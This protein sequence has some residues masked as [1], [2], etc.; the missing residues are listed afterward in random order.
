M[1]FSPEALRALAL[2]STASVA[3]SAMDPIRW[4]MRGL[5]MGVTVPHAGTVTSAPAVQ[6]P[7]ALLPRDGR[8]G[9]GPSKVRPEAMAALAAAGRSWMGTSTGHRGDVVREVRSGLRELFALPDGWEVVLG[10]GGST[11]FW[12]VATFGLIESR[13]QHLVFG[14]FSGKFADAAARAPH[15]DAPEI[16]RS[17]PGTHP[18]PVAAASV[19]VCALTH[20]ETST[21]VM[22]DLRRPEGEALVVVDA[23]SGAGGLPWSPAEVDAYYFAPQK[24]F[25]SDGGLWL[26]AAFPTLGADR[27]D[28]HLGPLGAGLGI[29]VALENSR[30]ADLQHPAL[31]TLFLLTD[32]LRWMLRNG[33]L[34][35]C[36]ARSRRSARC[37]TAGPRAVRGEPFVPL[38]PNGRP[39]GTIDLTGSTPRSCPPPSRQRH[40]RHRLLSQAGAQPA[41]HRHVPRHPEDEALT[42]CIDHVVERLA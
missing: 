34:G 26:A 21:G 17:E 5:E 42:H 28:R 41:P 39:S 37:C 31:A 27:T 32:Q 7:A 29:C 22:M 24:C 15:L 19:D 33:G 12:D 36:V 18:A 16:I 1:T 23:T 4:E 38:R 11:A 2:A 25:G 6:I 20:N 8:F 3:D 35:W 14:E 10:N 9:C 30:R 13:S 40:R